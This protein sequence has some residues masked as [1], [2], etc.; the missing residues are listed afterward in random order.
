MSLVRSI[1]ETSASRFITITMRKAIRR[2]LASATHPMPVA[3]DKIS[4][5]DEQ[6]VDVGAA[7]QAYGVRSDVVTS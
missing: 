7:G 3:N 6:R 4:G 2:A 1:Q 5:I